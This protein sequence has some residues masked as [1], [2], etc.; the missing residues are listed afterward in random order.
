MSLKFSLVCSICKL[1]FKDPVSLPCSCAICSEHLRDDNAKNGLIKCMKCDQ[2]FE[3][4]ENGFTPSIIMANTLEN[5]LHL[6]EEEKTIKYTIHGLIMQLEQLKYDLEQK[7]SDIER[8]SF[9][10]FLEI[11]RK[12]DK[13]QKELKT[14]IDEIAQKMTNQANEKENAYKLKMKNSLLNVDI[15]HSRRLLENEYRKPNLTIENA[16]RMQIE[17]ELKIAEMQSRLAD[18]NYLNDEIKSFEFEVSLKEPVRDDTFG[19]FK[20]SKPSGLIACSVKTKIKIWNLRTNECVVSLD[21]HSKEIWCLET[22]DENRF[23]SGSFDKTVKI[24]DA[25]EFVCLKTLADHRNEVMCLM[26]L[27]PNRIASGSFGEIKIWDLESGRCMQ[28]LYVHSDLI[29]D[30]ICLPNGNLVSCSWDKSLKMWDLD[31]GTCLKT[32][33]G[34]SGYVYCLLLLKNGHVASGSADNTIKIWNVQSGE[35]VKT[36]RGH[37]TNVKRLQLLGSCELISCSGDGT[38]K[39]WDLTEESCIKTLVGHTDFIMSIKINRQ[40]NTLVSCSLDGT[41][42]AWNLKTGECVNTISDPEG[43][44]LLDLIII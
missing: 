27:V 4:S 2:E 11:R 31:K 30:L 43:G 37:T 25:K 3:I 22:I 39:I 12:I 10:H 24:W 17:H 44:Q 36:L 42:K 14:K 15:F 16:K 20:L 1:V 21:G 32:M 40:N 38:I 29:N 7:Y 19:H 33:R 26:S 9:E 23:A 6:S 35:C 5:E 13:Q 18:L 34:H 41:I 28:T 8:A